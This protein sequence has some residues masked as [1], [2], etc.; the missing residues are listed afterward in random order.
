MRQ[1]L[2]SRKVTVMQFYREDSL[3]VFLVVLLLCAVYLISIH[4]HAG[5]KTYS[6]CAACRVAYTLS[7]GGETASF[8][9]VLPEFLLTETVFDCIKHI[10]GVCIAPKRP[11]APPLSERCPAVMIPATSHLSC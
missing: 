11:R 2:R 1:G 8:V 6:N 5:L 10:P 9:L 3:A 7:G 4:R